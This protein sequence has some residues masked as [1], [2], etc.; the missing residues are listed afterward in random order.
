MQPEDLSEMMRRQG[1]S[2]EPGQR[3]EGAVMLAPEGS[4]PALCRQGA[5]EE[6]L[7]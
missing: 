4:S 7:C 2:T 1:S 6:L 5:S 3:A